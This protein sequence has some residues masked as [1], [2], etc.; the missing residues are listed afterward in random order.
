M[1]DIKV[2]F[3]D[4]DGVLINR[5]CFGPGI[6]SGFRSKPDP[7][8]I[9]RLNRITDTTGA[10]IVVSST[11][12]IMPFMELKETLISWGIT[13]KIMDVTPRLETAK[14]DI[15]LSV[16]RGREIKAWI[17]RN[18]WRNI[19]AVCILDDDSD[20][21]HMADKLI[22]TQFTYGLQDEHVARAI[23]ML[24]ETPTK[25]VQP[26]IGVRS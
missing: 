1:R 24:N 22:Q 9:A 18:D 12:R 16:P 2:L 20:M 13:A 17:A 23:R 10:V 11:W 6:P 5:S 7:D 25:N 19:T 15:T 26:V 14:G 3:L 8:C 21:E 4:I